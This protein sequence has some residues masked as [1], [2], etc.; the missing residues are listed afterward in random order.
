MSVFIPIFFISAFLVVVFQVALEMRHDLKLRIFSRRV[1]SE[2]MDQ[3][4]L[5]KR[6]MKQM[7]RME[8]YREAEPIVETLE[9]KELFHRLIV[10]EDRNLD[11]LNKALAHR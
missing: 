7:K 4:V 11:V 6:L 1:A 8:I 2:K 9:T 10:E 3:R 5:L